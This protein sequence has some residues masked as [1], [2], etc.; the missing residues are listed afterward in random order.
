[1][2]CVRRLPAV[3][4]VN[5]HNPR[6]IAITPL[7]I[8]QTKGAGFSKQ[9]QQRRQDGA[10]RDDEPQLNPGARDERVELGHLPAE[11]LP[12]DHCQD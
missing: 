11:Y 5:A 9:S 10:E 7:E 4:N 1:M 3:G 12:H 6:M 8:R 2:R